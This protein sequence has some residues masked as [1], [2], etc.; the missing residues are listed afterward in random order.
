M[1][2]WIAF[3]RKVV[4][5]FDGEGRSRRGPQMSATPD[6][7]LANPEQLIADLQ[8][9]LAERDAELAECKAER[10][11]AL[12]QQTAT[13]EVLQVINSSPGDLRPVFDAILDKARRLCETAFGIL[14]TYDGER[15]HA[16][17][18]N[19]AADRELYEVH[20]RRRFL[21]DDLGAR[22]V[23]SVALRK[24]GALL[25][26]I[27]VYRQEVRP[28]TDKQIALLQNQSRLWAKLRAACGCKEQVRP[29]ESLLS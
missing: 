9:Q 12:E 11:E 18:F 16:A 19:M 3:K 1:P 26:G 27:G 23:L 20:P 13:A 7:T 25:G 24:D 22:T 10:D 29:D 28:F 17:A 8:R 4:A 5:A 14:W 21:V 6:S 15:F 2:C